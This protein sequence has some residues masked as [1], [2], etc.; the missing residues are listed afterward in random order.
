MPPT[1]DTSVC[2]EH[3]DFILKLSACSWQTAIVSASIQLLS[4][5]L[6][7]TLLF[8]KEKPASL[9]SSHFLKNPCSLI[10]ESDTHLSMELFQINYSAWRL[11]STLLQNKGFFRVLDKISFPKATAHPASLPLHSSSLSCSQLGLSEERVLGPDSDI[12]LSSVT[13]WLVRPATTSRGTLPPVASG[14][15][16]RAHPAKRKPEG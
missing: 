4:D 9:L 6:N 16:S 1:A 10:Q 11:Y 3:Y 2:W 5:N 13:R 12:P 8:P 14:R 15:W 7:P